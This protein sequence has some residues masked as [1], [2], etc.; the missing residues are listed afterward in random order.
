MAMMARSIGIPSRV[1]VGYASGDYDAAANTWTV[2][3][4][5]AHAWPELYL[6]GQGWTRWEPT[7]IRPVP[8]RLTTPNSPAPAPVAEEEPVAPTRTTNWSLIAISLVLIAGF[9]GAL[10]FSRRT[11]PLNPAR[12]LAELY[13]YGRRAGIP[14][15]VGDSIEEYTD[16]L[17]RSVPVVKMPAERVGHLLTARAYRQ[18]P[19]STEEETALLRSWE[20][21]RDMLPQQPATPKQE[22]MN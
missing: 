16:R 4:L 13:R 1:V 3:E 19:L 22:A 14:P 20:N 15:R 9:I 10:W 2:H 17:G 7:P 18:T 21:A 12:V 8:A 5:D 6:E 11:S